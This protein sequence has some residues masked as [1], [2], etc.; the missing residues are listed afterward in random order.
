MKYIF[1]FKVALSAKSINNILRLA[2][3]AAAC[4][5]LPTHALAQSSCPA[6]LNGDGEVDSSDLG[7][8]LLVYG[9]CPTQSSCPADLNGDGEVDS[10]DLGSFLLAYGPCPE[11]TISAVSPNTGTSY[12]GTTI[13]ITGTNL[14][15]TSRVQVG[16]SNNATNI[17]V[18]NDTTVTAVTPATGTYGVKNV[19]VTT[20]VGTV[21]LVGAFTYF[22]S[23]WYTP[24]EQAPDPDVVKDPA[25]RAKIVATGFPWRVSDKGTGIEML[26]IPGGTFTMGC[27]PYD[28]GNYADSC[29]PD[30]DPTHQVTLTKAFYLGK[31][32]VTQKQWQDKMGNNPSGFDNA[33]DSPSRP[34]ENVTWNDVAGFNTD[35]YLRLPTEAEWEYACRGGTTTAIHSTPERPNGSN[36]IEQ[37]D[38][39][40]WYGNIYGHTHAVAGKAPNAFGF[41][42]MSG[43]VW[44]WCNDRY[45]DYSAGNA[46]D[47]A[48]PSSG[49]YRVTRGGG[50]DTENYYCRS[51][52]RNDVGPGN[53]YKGLGFRVARHP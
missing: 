28:A 48:G 47:P 51:S 21:T 14:I 7:F 5:A 42:D 34:V 36:K 22:D 53:S 23:S 52:N 29:D 18:V 24:L 16:W 39:I 25:V 9:P 31:T 3:L 32:E 45:G 17:V 12:G 40:A 43:N 20:T 38:S 37:L 30:E 4:L 6:D 13:T 15:G 11:P 49:S 10:S 50:W 1:N 33:S 19:T 2:T 44:E 35:T 26:L 41:Y 8:F 27:S 46:T